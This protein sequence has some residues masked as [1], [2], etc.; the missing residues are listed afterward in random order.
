MLPPILTKMQGLGYAVFVRGDYN[1]N[2]IGIRSAIR[3]AGAFDDLIGLVYRVDGRWIEQWWPATTDPAPRTGT[4]ILV[5]GQY[6][7][8]YGIDLHRGKYPALCQR[9]GRVR[10]YRDANRDEILDMDPATIEEGYFGINIHAAA[11]DPYAENID[12]TDKE[13]GPWS[14]GCQVFARTA[15]FQAFMSIVKRSRQ[16]YGP[17]FTYTLLTEAQAHG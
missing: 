7:G 17:R 6:R 8:V 2:I 5:P 4:A 10:V 3:R 13:I 1:L 12:L 14:A 16:L 11:N 9:F 15:D